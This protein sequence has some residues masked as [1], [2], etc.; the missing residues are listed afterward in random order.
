[1]VTSK[2]LV[3]C[4]NSL[5]ESRR[6]T[7]Q[8][9][10]C[11]NVLNAVES[12]VVEHRPEERPPE[13]HLKNITYGRHWFTLPLHRNFHDLIHN[14]IISSKVDRVKEQFPNL[15]EFSEVVAFELQ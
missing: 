8:H 2:A 10:F 3:G 6:K 4:K 9:S 11:W 5:I 7:L 14:S 15:A 1:M 13:G 12:D